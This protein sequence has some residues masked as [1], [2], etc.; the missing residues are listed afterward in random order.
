MESKKP[1]SGM[2]RHLR[3]KMVPHFRRG[4]GKK[5][6]A[7]IDASMDYRMSSSVPDM[8]DMKQVFFQRPTWTRHP[9]SDFPNYSS[10]SS[11]LVKPGRAT[12]GGSGMKSTLTG[13]ITERSQHRLS[14]P[15]DYTDWAPY[16]ESHGVSEDRKG[17]PGADR[18]ITAS[19]E[20]EDQIPPETM[21]DNA[22]PPPQATSQDTSQVKSPEDSPLCHEKKERSSSCFIR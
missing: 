20:P 2:L 9:Q 1:S 21:H 8:R 16:Q 14:A 22:D 19:M 4:K 13:P 11:P 5:L 3:Q 6:P 18:R 12:E 15:L 7:E 17:S 10:P